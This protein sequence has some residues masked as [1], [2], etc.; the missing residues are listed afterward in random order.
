MICGYDMELNI[1]FIIPIASVDLKLQR[2]IW[3]P[4]FACLVAHA[5]LTNVG[6]SPT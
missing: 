6:Y 2:M 4:F 1:Q 5:S 3:L